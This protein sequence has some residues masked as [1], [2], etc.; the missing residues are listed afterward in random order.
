MQYF[1]RTVEYI[2]INLHTIGVSDQDALRKLASTGIA[3]SGYI[4]VLM[5]SEE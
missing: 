2:L 4:Q 5:L 1:C 3:A